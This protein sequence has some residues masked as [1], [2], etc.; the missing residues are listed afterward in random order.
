MVTAA[1]ELEVAATPVKAVQQMVVLDLPIQAVVVVVVRLL[2][3]QPVQV[4]QAAPV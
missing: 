2:V 3:P 4:A 1:W